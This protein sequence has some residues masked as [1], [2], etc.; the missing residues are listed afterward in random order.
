MQKDLVESGYFVRELAAS[1]SRLPRFSTLHFCGNETLPKKFPDNGRFILRS[2]DDLV[3]A[4]ASPFTTTSSLPDLVVDPREL[5]PARLLSELP[6][7]IRDAG[8][9]LRH[10][11]VLDF[12][13]QPNNVASLLPQGP[14]SSVIPE[15]D[16][17]NAA[18]ENLESVLV[19]GPTV[20]SSRQP[21]GPGWWNSVKKYLEAVV[22]G[23]GLR[24]IV[25]N[26]SP[27]AWEWYK[28][29]D[30]YPLNSLLSSI[31][32]PRLERLQVNKVYFSYRKMKDFCARLGRDPVDLWLTEAKMLGG[33]WDGFVKML[34]RR[35]EN[36][37]LN[38]NMTFHKLTS[39]LD[40]ETYCLTTKSCNIHNATTPL[41]AC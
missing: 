30:L 24:S 25:I 11:T 18:F 26:G 8:A 17:L 16:A 3:A 1:I 15:W 41:S 31:T 23:P 7:A 27:T 5:A 9:S 34:H 14:T 29:D 21:I 37:G 35:R 38:M 13:V 39:D 28:C 2:L 40:D 4:M 36:Q 33:S 6:I 32:S 20:E 19:T 10:L 22:S 12:P